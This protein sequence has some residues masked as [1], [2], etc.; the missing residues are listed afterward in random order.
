MFKI[1]GEKERVVSKWSG[2]VTNQLYIY[3]EDGDYGK[4]DFKFRIS[5]ATTEIEESTFT[6][7]E[8]VN[9]VIS[10]LEGKMELEHVG[11]HN[12]TLN[13]YE[14][15]RFK[16]EWET[17]SKGKVTDFNLMIKDGNGDFFFK[18][19]SKKGNILFSDKDAFGFVFCIDGDLKI[20]EQEIKKG[21]ILI[22]DNK[23]IKVT[24]NGKI[25]YGYIE[26]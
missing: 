24:G 2:G 3:P 26:K 5:I 23:E 22:T 6:K 16:G 8:N 1:L 13:K 4:R 12:K 15:D 21:E 19:V 10:I 25:F 18:E 11:H 14:I 7:L 9:R 20:D 17:H